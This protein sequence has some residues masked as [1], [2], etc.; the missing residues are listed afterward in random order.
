LWQAAC[1][2]GAGLVLSRTSAPK[3]EEQEAASEVL[4]P[5]ASASTTKIRAGPAAHQAR[6][7]VPS[8]HEVIRNNNY[9]CRPRDRQKS[10]RRINAF[11]T[12]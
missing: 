12:C 4:P 11:I 8:E 6:P 2:Y 10:R 7:I 3:E 5:A 1:G 9:Q